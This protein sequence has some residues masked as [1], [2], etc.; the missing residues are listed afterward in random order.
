METVYGGVQQA[1]LLS[2]ALLLASPGVRACIYVCKPWALQAMFNRV[3]GFTVQGLKFI[4]F[5]AKGT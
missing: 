3:P 1:T 2:F 5:R 4:G